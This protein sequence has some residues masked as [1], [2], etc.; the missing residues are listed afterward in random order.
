MKINFV[1]FGNIC[2]SP[3]AEYVMK[4]LVEKAGLSDKI[5]VESSGCHATGYSQI[6]SGTCFELAKN[7]I[8]FDPYRISRKFEETDYKNCDY[9]VAMDKG[10][11]ADIKKITGDSSG[12]KIFLM[13]EFAGEN[14]DVA[15]PY[16]TD[17]YETT[18]K[19]ISR[20]C[21]ALLKRLAACLDR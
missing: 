6:S 12:K 16:I 3:M 4:N 11:F 18:Y 8:P 7:N 10:N 2:R 21:T 15:D 19:D 1:C 13:L 20:A 9:I 5:S 17:D 14:R